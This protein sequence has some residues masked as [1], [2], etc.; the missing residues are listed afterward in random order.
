MDFL[1]WRT[2]ASYNAN[3]YSQ[4]EFFNFLVPNMNLFMKQVQRTSA[5]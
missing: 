3:Q 5:K 1:L 2:S 4:K